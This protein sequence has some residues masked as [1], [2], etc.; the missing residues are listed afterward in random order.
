MFNEIIEN[1]KWMIF[2]IKI[3]RTIHDV[4]EQTPDNEYFSNVQCFPKK[5]EK[6]KIGHDNATHIYVYIHTVKKRDTIQ[7]VPVCRF[8]SEEAL[9]K[10]MDARACC[11]CAQPL[12]VS[13][14]FAPPHYQHNFTTKKLPYNI[15]I[16]CTSTFDLY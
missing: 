7:T 9:G 15:F 3:T 5:R 14:S 8:C 1:K 13:F 16:T 12:L 2:K 4:N 10:A 6:K 11:C